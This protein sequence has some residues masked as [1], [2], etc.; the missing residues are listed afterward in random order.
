M[1]A[2]KDEAETAAIARASEGVEFKP[3]MPEEEPPPL[4]PP[5]EAPPAPKAAATVVAG[6]AVSSQTVKRTTLLE[7]TTS[8][9]HTPCFGMSARAETFK[10]K[11]VAS[12]NSRSCKRALKAAQCEGTMFEFCMLA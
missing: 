12:A 8:S 6:A 9:K 3:P 7:L 4:P 10:Q 5:E 1:Q 11:K 2:E